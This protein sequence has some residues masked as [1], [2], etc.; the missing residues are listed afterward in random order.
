[1]PHEPLHQLPLIFLRVLRLSIAHPSIH[2]SIY[3]PHLHSG[4]AHPHHVCTAGGRTRVGNLR[5]GDGAQHNTERWRGSRQATGHTAQELSSRVRK[6]PQRSVHAIDEAGASLALGG[7]VGA[8]AGYCGSTLASLKTSCMYRPAGLDGRFGSF[9]PSSPP[10]LAFCTAHASHENERP[11]LM[12]R[13][14]ARAG[15]CWQH[16]ERCLPSRPRRERP[17]W[18]PSRP[19][20]ARAAAP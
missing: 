2:L 9:S 16:G 5:H 12:Q 6:G 18:T 13:A 20:R 11:P 3:L 4:W 19:Q 15:S 10:R 17:L 7:A 8:L 14:R 1:M